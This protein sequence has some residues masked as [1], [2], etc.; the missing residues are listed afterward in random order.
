MH[1]KVEFTWTQKQNK[2]FEA[3][4]K[5]LTNKPVLQIFDSKKEVTLTTATSECGIAAVVS[6]EGHPVR[7]LSIKLTSAECNYSNIEKEA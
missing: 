6:Q 5:V 4:K 3:L 7:Y 1:K 2:A